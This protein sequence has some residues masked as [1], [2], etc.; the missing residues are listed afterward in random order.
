MPTST[1]SRR[2]ARHA[3]LLVAA[4]LALLLAPPLRAQEAPDPAEACEDHVLASG[5]C[6]APRPWRTASPIS[7]AACGG[8]PRRWGR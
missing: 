3:T 6:L 7:T 1:G 4:G 2:G 5:L 8:A